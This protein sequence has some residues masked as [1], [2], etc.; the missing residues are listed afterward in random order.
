[1]E[2]VCLSAERKAEETEQ[3]KPKSDDEPA[4]IELKEGPGAQ[5]PQSQ[6]VCTNVFNDIERI[7]EC[8]MS[9][10][11]K[12]ESDKAEPCT[13]DLLKIEESEQQ[14]DRDETSNDAAQLVPGESAVRVRGASAE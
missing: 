6:K 7:Q 12:R 2:K 8:R 1:M 4:K 13:P 10:R 11:V 14:A 9:E 3:A 5:S